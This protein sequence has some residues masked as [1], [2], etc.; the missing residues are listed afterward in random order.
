MERA[1]KELAG[2]KNTLQG[3]SRDEKL[4]K[5][6][7]QHS[8]D[9]TKLNPV[10]LSGY[11]FADSEALGKKMIEFY[12][13]WTPKKG[14]PE[15][16]QIGSLYGFD[17]FIRQQREGYEDK[18][19][20]QYRFENHL[21]A[22]GP[23]GIKYQSNGGHPNTDNPKMAARYYLNAIDKVLGLREKYE[24]QQAELETEIP[25]LKELSQK[26]FEKELELAEL[27]VELRRLEGEIAAKIRET[28]MKALPPDEKEQPEIGVGA[29][30]SLD[31]SENLQPLRKQSL[32]PRD[33]PGQV[34]G[35]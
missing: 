26:T 33:Y 7:L 27:R 15:E 28:Q 29:D 8:A 31:H 2:C 25:T 1:E 4:Y 30:D 3:L 9:G 19:I 32:L 13:G 6:E 16:K 14:E 10:Q 35:G 12:R 34:L 5:K 21:F 23:G 18:G 24:K 22:Q 17:L 11:Q 20:F